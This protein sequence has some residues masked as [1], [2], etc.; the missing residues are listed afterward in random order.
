MCQ[1][2]GPHFAN[3]HKPANFLN[4]KHYQ[5]LTWGSLQMTAWLGRTSGPMPPSAASVGM[6]GTVMREL[7]ISSG[8]LEKNSWGQ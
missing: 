8:R 7:A 5:Q 1:S 3:F 4:L 6:Q 2:K